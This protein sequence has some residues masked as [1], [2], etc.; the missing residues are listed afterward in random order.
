MSKKYT[1]G[2]A[3]PSCQ[4]PKVILEDISSKG[5]MDLEYFFQDGEHVHNKVIIVQKYTCD[6]N[7]TFSIE[8]H[9]RCPNKE[10]LYKEFNQP[11]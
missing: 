4:S 10:C 11:P 1:L 9:P 6:N 3:C 5:K 2:M 8:R 7:H